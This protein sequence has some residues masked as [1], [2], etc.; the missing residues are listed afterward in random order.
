MRTSATRTITGRVNSDGTLASG[1][2]VGS[3]RNSVGNYTLTFASS[4][5]LLQIILV[6]YQSG[7]TV[8][9]V[10]SGQ[11][12]RTVLLILAAATT[13]AGQDSGFVFTAVGAA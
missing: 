4:F 1:T 8:A 6:P 11:T 3:R 2:E 5:R 12:D 7:N 13:G 9:Y 10:A